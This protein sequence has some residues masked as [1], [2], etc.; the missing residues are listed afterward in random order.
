MSC[1]TPQQR[2]HA[3]AKQDTKIVCSIDNIEATK[4]DTRLQRRRHVRV[5]EG[6]EVANCLRAL[7]WR[8][9]RVNRRPGNSLCGRLR[10]K[11]KAIARHHVLEYGEALDVEAVSLDRGQQ[12]E[13][14]APADRC[15]QVLV[16]VLVEAG[17][18]PT[19]SW[20]VNASQSCTCQH[21]DLQSEGN[22]P[23]ALFC[24]AWSPSSLCSQRTASNS[25]NAVLFTSVFGRVTSR[26]PFTDIN[27]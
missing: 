16:V 17:D 25:S 9:A 20:T 5:E 22:L 4:I 23:H 8:R 12:Q 7:P 1:L 13:G 2:Q 14:L 27:I 26:R 19:V 6:W 18:A 10:L 11:R 15:I 3:G 24:L 21:E